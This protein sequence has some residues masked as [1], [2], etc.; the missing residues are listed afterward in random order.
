MNIL[1]NTYYSPSFALRMFTSVES[2]VSFPACRSPI[3]C[4]Q[5]YYFFLFPLKKKREEE[6]QGEE[7]GAVEPLMSQIDPRKIAEPERRH[8]P[9]IHDH[10]LQGIVHSW[11]VSSHAM[12]IMRRKPVRLALSESKHSSDVS[13][14]HNEIECQLKRDRV[15]AKNEIKM[16]LL[17]A[18]ESGK[19]R[20][21]R[22]SNRTL[23]TI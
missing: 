20:V 17:G 9:Q 11:A 13:A 10:H 2:L 16:L 1:H 12:S 21:N 8:S 5:V 3:K 19:V 18:G 7:I 4:T 15:L 22:L 6:K 23:F 14:G